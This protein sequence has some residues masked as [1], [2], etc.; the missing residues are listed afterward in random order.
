MSYE[1]RPLTLAEILDAAFRLVQTEWRTLVGL[2]MIMQIPLIALGSWAEWLFD[3]LADPVSPGEEVTP[4]IVKKFK[5]DV[6]ILARGSRFG[7][8]TVPGSNGA[9]VKNL[10]QFLKGDREVGQ[11]VAVLGVKGAELAVSFARQGKKVTL[12]NEGPAE[13]IHDVPWLASVT[14]RSWVLLDYMMKEPNLTLVSSAKIHEITNEGVIY[15]SG[16]GEKETLKVD[17]V[18]NAINQVPRD[19][20]R[21][22]EGDGYQVIEI[23]DC[24]KPGGIIRDA[25]FDANFAVRMKMEIH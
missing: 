5:P 3:P 18:I 15:T 23:G 13:A 21:A 17:T 24:A 4:E 12:L 16:Q 7:E 8:L 20:D 14:N 10:D 9:I 19:V 1:L 2:S 25:I 22:I 11:N 6:V